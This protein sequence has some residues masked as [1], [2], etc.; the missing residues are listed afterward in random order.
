MVSI[1]ECFVTCSKSTTVQ[2][3]QLSV[4]L[5]VS[6]SSVIALWL[7]YRMLIGLDRS[8]KAYSKELCTLENS[9]VDF[10]IIPSI[11]SSYIFILQ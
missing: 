9:D 1:F 7:F 6:F 5:A 10:F 8:L 2:P 3:E 11:H 4:L